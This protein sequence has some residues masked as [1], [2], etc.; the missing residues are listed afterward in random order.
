MGV[1]GYHDHPDNRGVWVPL[2]VLRLL[3]GDFATALLLSQLLWWHQPARNGQPRC[4]HERDGHRWLLRADD[5]WEGELGLT[6]KQ[7]RRSR[8]VLTKAGLVEC[9]RFKR[10]GAPTSAWRPLYEALSAPNRPEPEVPPEGQFHGSAPGGPDGSAP[11]GQLPTALSNRNELTQPNQI[12]APPSP[13]KPNAEHTAAAKAI[14]NAW[15][16]AQNPRPVNDYMGV[17]KVVAAFLAAGHNPGRVAYALADASCPTKNALLVEL[18]REHRP[19]GRPPLHPALREAWRQYASDV[20]APM[21]GTG[22]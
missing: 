7:V 17:V 11:G 5:E 6:A 12:P 1:S 8:Q 10:D 3:D 9:R 2:W 20:V 22:S 19:S 16:E 18:N 13:P 15:W 21:Y 4:Q 14:V